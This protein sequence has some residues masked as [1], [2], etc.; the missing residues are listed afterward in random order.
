MLRQ[1]KSQSLKNKETTGGATTQIMK[2]L[3]VLRTPNLRFY[4]LLMCFAWFSAALVYFGISLGTSVLVGNMYWNCFLSGLVE[5][6]AY[7]ANVY[8]LERFGRKLPMCIYQVICSV[9]LIV[10]F[11]IPLLSA[12]GSDLTIPIVTLTMIAKFGVTAVFSGLHLITAEIYPTVVRNA[13][14]GVSSVCARLAATLSPFFVH[15]STVSSSQYQLLIFGSCGLLSIIVILLMPETADV[16]L[17]DTLDDCHLL[18]G[19]A[20]KPMDSSAKKD[21]LSA[22]L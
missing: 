21:E 5:I 20:T 1:L 14:L 12:S 3:L 17:M 22:M 10:I 19:K 15:L 2:M 11:F 4:A 7:I 6:P 8:L 16:P 9:P 13:G 18:E